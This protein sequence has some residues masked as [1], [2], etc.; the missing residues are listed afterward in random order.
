MFDKYLFHNTALGM[1]FL[2]WI[3]SSAQIILLPTVEHGKSSITE[4]GQYLGGACKE[5]EGV[6]ALDPSL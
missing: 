2:T 5:N 3:L 6:M 1:S 4:C